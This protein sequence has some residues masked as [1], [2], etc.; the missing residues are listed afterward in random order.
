[1]GAV[2]SHRR[3]LLDP[4]RQFAEGQLRR[5]RPGG[6]LPVHLVLARQSPEPAGAAAVQVPERIV[7]ADVRGPVREAAGKAGFRRRQRAAPI[8]RGLGAVAAGGRRDVEADPGGEMGR[9]LQSR[10]DLALLAGSRFLRR[11]DD[12]RFHAFGRRRRPILP[13]L[14]VRGRRREIA[15]PAGT[16]IERCVVRRGRGDSARRARPRRNA[17]GYR[18]PGGVDARPRA[19][20]PVRARSAASGNC[21]TAGSSS[22]TS[23]ARFLWLSSRRDGSAIG[24]PLRP[25]PSGG[26]SAG[27]VSR[28][29]RCPTSVC[30]RPFD[31]S[32]C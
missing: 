9:R 5:V 32:R 8:S 10:A 20:S 30:R 19:A 14:A 13:P 23:I 12:R 6:I 11:G 1:M 22:A 2:S 16:R 25:S 3:R 28:R 18:R 4:E 27:K 17:G 21:R 26:R 31:L 24:A 29:S 15:P 7:R